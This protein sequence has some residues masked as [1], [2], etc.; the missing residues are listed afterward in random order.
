MPAVTPLFMELVKDYALAA[1]EF[2]HLK[3][4]TIAQWMLES[5]RGSSKLATEHLNFAGLKWREEMVGFASKISYVAHD[6]TDCYC[7]FATKEKFIQGYW[8]FIDRPPYAGW[9]NDAATGAS[10]IEFV[11]PRYT[12]TAGY[13]S[14]V[15]NLLGEAQGLLSSVSGTLLSPMHV[16]ATGNPHV[17]PPIKPFISSP[18]HSSRNGAIIRRIV[19]HYTTAPNAQSTITWFQ[20]NPLSV[21]AHYI[22]DKNGDIY[23]M[24]HDSERAHHCKGANADTIGIEHVAVAGDHLTVQQQA[25]TVA[26]I[27]WLV[28]EYDIAPRHITGH[29]F[30]PGYTG[31]TN[32]PNV[33]FGAFSEAAITAW[34]AQHIA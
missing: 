24:V 10:Y 14:A 3:P 21:S 26:L 13:A 18:Y 12:P 6:G 16:P 32:C 1:I 4:V 7:E 25:A 28:A 30:T 19:L 22:V 31:S 27:R 9:R 34:V 2:E 23:Q 11:G 5:G 20:N 17:K 15:L 8:R 29:N 33:L